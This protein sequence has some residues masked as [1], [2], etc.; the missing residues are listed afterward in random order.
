MPSARCHVTDLFT[1][2]RAAFNKGAALEQGFDAL[3]RDGWILIWDADTLFPDSVP[4]IDLHPAKLYGAK[5]RILEDPRKWSPDF[6][7]WKSLPLST[8]TGWP[9]FFQLFHGS[10]QRISKR[11]W[12]DV[13]YTHAGGG[14]GYFQSRWQDRDKGYLPIEVLHLGPRDANWFGRV[15]ARADGVEIEDGTER[16]EEMERLLSAYGWGGRQREREPS[17]TERIIPH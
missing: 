12:Y 14:D 10:C 3:G 9:G 7:A 5:R 15:S 4:F 16:T 8:E 2:D 17:F 11:P 1:R 13:T 6:V